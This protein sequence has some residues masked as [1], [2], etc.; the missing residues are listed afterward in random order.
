MNHRRLGVLPKIDLG[1]WQGSD[2]KDIALY[3]MII[4]WV[5]RQSECSEPPRKVEPE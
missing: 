3:V 2:C 4:V 5:P 1:S